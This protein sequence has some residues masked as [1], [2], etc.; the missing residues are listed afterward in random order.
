MASTHFNAKVQTISLDNALELDLSKEAIEYL[1]TKGILHQTSWV[2]TPQQ[3]VVVERKHKHL[4]ETSRALLFH[5]NLPI[6]YWGECVL[7]A[8]Y[9][10]NTATYLINRFPSKVL[11]GLSPFHLLFGKKPTYD[12][13]KVFG[14][15]CY[16]LTLK[17]GRD[18]F[19]ARPVPY[20]FLGYPFGKKAY[21][22][23]NLETHQVFTSRDV[24]FHEKTLPYK[25]IIGADNST[26]FPNFSFHEYHEHEPCSNT[27]R[28]QLQDV[29]TNSPLASHLSPPINRNSQHTSNFQ[30]VRRSRRPHKTPTYLSD[31][32]CS[33]VLTNNHTF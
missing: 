1:M 20:V 5:S 16:T 14:S 18:K 9:L 15:L 11:K 19:Q 8:T 3:N 26:I 21:K 30:S 2:G 23:L 32:V 31:Y 28:E 17:S 24:V 7:T 33:N 25:S 4:L 10:I 22:V 27:T 29:S 12:H 6:K 13:L